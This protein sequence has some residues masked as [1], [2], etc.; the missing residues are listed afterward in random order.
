MGAEHSALRIYGGHEALYVQ[1]ASGVTSRVTGAAGIGIA[2]E[3]I[4]ANDFWDIVIIGAGVAGLA[5]AAELA[6]SGR[7]ILILEARDRI[8]GRAWTRHEPELSA[9]IELGAEFIHG[10]VIETLELLQEV[11]KTALDTS[12]AH[13]SAQHGKLAQRT[14][15]LFSEIQRVLEQSNILAE[16]DVS[17]ETFLSRSERH[18]LSPDAL[19]LARAFVE[20][21]D[22]ADP[23]RVSA[24]SI[25]EEW[26]SGGMLD[27]PQ[28]RPLG[29]YS[30]VLTALAGALDRRKVKL[31]LQTTVRAVRWSRGSVEVE[32]VFLDQPLRVAASRVIVTLPLGVLQLPPDAPGAVR[33]TPG[34]DAKSEALQGLASGPVIKV[35]LRFRKAFWE[36]LD[37][38]RYE[39]ASFFHSPETVFPTFWTAMPLRAPLLN[40]WVGGPKAA[41]LSS[42]TD[43][44]IVRQALTSL[45]TIFGGRHESEFQLEAA[46]LHNWQQDPLARGAYS[47]VN[48]GG[49]RARQSLAAPLQNTLFFAGEATDTESEPATVAAALHSGARAAREVSDSFKAG[50]I[51]RN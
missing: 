41:R 45:G 49:A 1:N 34:L 28:F 5:A 10:R 44:E 18:G 12:G 50:E 9:P 4:M 13:W 27:A 38:G 25:A 16:Q 21:F 37:G 8:G 31:Q 40:A 35:A 42:G 29:G 32:G 14:E 3:L 46:Y 39:D 7:S 43:A 11:G 47:Y 6:R 33:F 51:L 30:S 19:A 48:V 22:A 20:G 24:H 15:D 17:F 26:R 2:N 36:E 23:A